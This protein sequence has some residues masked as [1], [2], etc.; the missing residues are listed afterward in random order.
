MVVSVSRI[1]KEVASDVIQRA[2][3][4]C[5]VC[6]FS[7]HGMEMVFHH[8]QARGMGGSK[9][10]RLDVAANLIYVHRSCHEYVHAHPDWS[11]VQG[12]IVSQ[13]DETPA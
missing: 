3:N 1:P 10:R 11:R 9:G 2:E 8:R 12:F 6:Q 7:G 4:C 5:E 13:Y